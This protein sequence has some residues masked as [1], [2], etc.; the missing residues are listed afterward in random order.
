MKA[1]IAGI[2]GLIALAL[3]GMS[4][5]GAPA[6][7]KCPAACKQQLRTEFKGCKAAC[8][9]GSAGKTCKATCRA[10]KKSD[11]ASCKQATNPT[12]PGCGEASPSGAFLN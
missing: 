5:G 7:A 4:L 3:L 2:T 8:P 11:A 1:G 10:E 9:K 6:M 12:P